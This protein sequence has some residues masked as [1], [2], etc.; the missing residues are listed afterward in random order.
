MRLSQLVNV[1]QQLIQSI[2]AFLFARVNGVL[3]AFFVAGDVPVAVE[4]VRHR[5]VLLLEARHDL[6]EQFFFESSRMRRH[7]VEIGILR[8]EVFDHFGVIPLI[9]P[10][11]VIDAG[12]AMDS[13]LFGSLGRN[14]RG[15]FFFRH[16]VLN[17]GT[18]KIK[19]RQLK[20]PVQ[21]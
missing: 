15:D 3:F 14:W 17:S 9:E 1:Q 18:K 21:L 11:I 7:S 20:A 13:Q 6:A 2:E 8:F 5:L 12:I 19:N 4:E 16:N 10:V